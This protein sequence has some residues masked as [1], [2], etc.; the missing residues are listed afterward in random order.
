M[1]HEF[2]LVMLRRI[3]VVSFQL[4]FPL[5]FIQIG[6]CGCWRAKLRYLIHI[7]HLLSVYAS[8]IPSSVYCP[9]FDAETADFNHFIAFNIIRSIWWN[10]CWLYLEFLTAVSMKIL[11]NILSQYRYTQPR[12]TADRRP[13]PPFLNL[14]SF[15]KAKVAFTPTKILMSVSKL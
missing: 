5:K 6:S 3:W 15:V 13:P 11:M 1:E 9:T 12:K 7:F 10:M 2:V 14:S 8:V 4:C